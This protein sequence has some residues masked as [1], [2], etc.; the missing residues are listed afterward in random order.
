VA[1]RASALLDRMIRHADVISEAVVTYD[2]LE[3][4]LVNMG[5]KSRTAEE[6]ESASMRVDAADEQRQEW[7]HDSRTIV[8]HRLLV[9]AQSLATCGSCTST[10]PAF[11]VSLLAL[12]VDPSAGPLR[13]PIESTLASILASLGV[14]ELST[15]SVSDDRRAVW[16]SLLTVYASCL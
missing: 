2:T 11:A 15:V 8:V 3:Q 10:A 16:S 6:S 13:G 9:V 5:R 14:Q 12:A 1:S 4:A 7:N